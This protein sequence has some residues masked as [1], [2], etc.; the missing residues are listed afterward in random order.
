MTNVISLCIDM[1][2]Y[3]NYANKKHTKE[4]K[5]LYAHTLRAKFTHSNMHSSWL[6]ECL[7]YTYGSTI[8]RSTYILGVENFKIE[9]VAIV[10][11][12]YIYGNFF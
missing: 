8:A 10:R 7:F 6:M 9:Q 3:F 4:N 12:N 11:Y 5:L 2:I 1:N